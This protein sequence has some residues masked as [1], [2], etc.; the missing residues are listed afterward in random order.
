[1]I[2][3][4]IF[5]ETKFQIM[6]QQTSTWKAALK[7]GAIL[8][9]ALIILSIIMHLAGIALESWSGYLSWLVMIAY[10][11]YATKNFRDEHRGGY[12]KYGNG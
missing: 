10:L 9:V 1:M 11:V 7:H 6:E 3:I 2:S 8:S 4:A 12:L 5:V